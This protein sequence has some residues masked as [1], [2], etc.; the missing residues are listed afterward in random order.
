MEETKDNFKPIIMGKVQ[1]CNGKM[2][3]LVLDI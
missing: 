2:M 1:D 3:K